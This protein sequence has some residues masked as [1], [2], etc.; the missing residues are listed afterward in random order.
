[1]C[2]IF[3]HIVTRDNQSNNLTF[4]AFSIGLKNGILTPPKKM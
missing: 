1:M 4:N 2:H 3:K